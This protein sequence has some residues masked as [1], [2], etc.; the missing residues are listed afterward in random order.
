MTSKKRRI[1]LGVPFEDFTEKMV[2]SGSY[3][4]ATEVI[5]DAL[6]KKMSEMEEDRIANIKSMV[7]EG[8]KQIEDGQFKK[9]DQKLYKS[10]LIKGIE[11]AKSGEEIL[12]HVI[13]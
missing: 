1:Y 12:S 13:S 11:K 10:I 9:V 8:Q 6:R 5:R 4:T 2:E 3:Y 7:L